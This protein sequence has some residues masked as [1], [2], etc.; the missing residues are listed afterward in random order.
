MFAVGQFACS[1]FISVELTDIVA[2]LPAIG[3]L[4][5]LLQVWQPSEPARAT[6]RRPR[7]AIAGAAASDPALEAEVRRKQDDHRDSPGEIAAAY[8]PYLNHHRGL[9]RRPDRGS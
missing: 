1:G 2:S 3:A 7:P 5:G 6:E 4:V 9:L 8:A